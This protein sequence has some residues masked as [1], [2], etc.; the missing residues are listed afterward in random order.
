M[1]LNVLVTLKTYGGG[2][3]VYPISNINTIQS[4]NCKGVLQCHVCP[5][6]TLKHMKSLVWAFQCHEEGIKIT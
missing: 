5:C 2:C 4:E 3:D 6:L 1:S